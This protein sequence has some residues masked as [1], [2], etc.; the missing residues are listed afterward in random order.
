MTLRKRGKINGIRTGLALAVLLGG[1]RAQSCVYF[2]MSSALV[3]IL[4]RNN[5]IESNAGVSTTKK[6]LNRLNVAL[7]SFVSTFAAARIEPSLQNSV[8][9]IWLF[10]RALRPMLPS[11]EIGPTLVMCLSATQLLSGWMLNPLEQYSNFF[12]RLK[13]HN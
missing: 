7:A 1:F 13:T 3:G 12:L 8:L 2:E 4:K 11:L 6:I 5:L 10:L 9:I